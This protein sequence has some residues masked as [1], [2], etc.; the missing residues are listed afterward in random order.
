MREQSER[1]RTCPTHDL[2][3]G[4]ATLLYTLTPPEFLTLLTMAFPTG[5][6][7]TPAFPPTACRAANVVRTAPRPSAENMASTYGVK[8]GDVDEKKFLV[9]G[10]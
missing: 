10:Q 7:T 4:A 9:T 3:S 1:E 8:T 5:L 6:L 2:E